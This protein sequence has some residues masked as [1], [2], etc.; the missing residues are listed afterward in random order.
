MTVLDRLLTSP[1]QWLAL[2]AV[3][4]YAAVGA[5]VVSQFQFN[6]QPCPWCTLQRF[7]FLVVGTLALL[8]AVLP[9][10]RLRRW[11]AVLMA[12]MAL[13]GASAALWLQ[14]V[15]SSSTSCKLT[16]ADK[17]MAGLGLFEIAPDLFVPTA[18]CAEAAVNLLGIPYAIWSL[19]LFLFC[20]L[21]GNRVAMSRLTY[22]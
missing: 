9:A 8:G 3:L 16:M 14:F 10:P 12:L 1:R 21:I 15:A 13:S 6:M 19:A 5:A 22:R 4:A 2:V 11:L 20:A 18:S 17:I 7:I